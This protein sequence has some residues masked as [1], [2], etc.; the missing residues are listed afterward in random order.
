MR[1]QDPL[2]SKALL[3]G[4]LQ[5]GEEGAVQVFRP[6]NSNDLILGAVGILQFDVVAWRLLEEYGVRCIYENIPVSTARWIFSQ[7]EKKLAEFRD[8]AIN[9]LAVDAGNRLTYLAPSLVNLHLIMER[10]P[11][12]RFNT[13]CE[14][15]FA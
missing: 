11:G 8:K 7:D 12:I 9:N 15:A 3:K 10:W 4:L 5:L 6:L 1:L 14:H 2:K 13:T